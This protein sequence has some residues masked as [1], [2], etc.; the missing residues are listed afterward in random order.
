[1]QGKE[2]KMKRKYNSNKREC[3]LRHVRHSCGTWNGRVGRVSSL[4]VQDGPRGG[5]TDN[6]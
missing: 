1:M 2:K 6:R 3:L 5:V 4:F